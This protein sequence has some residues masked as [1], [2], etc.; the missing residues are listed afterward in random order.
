MKNPTLPLL[1]APKKST[2]SN[3]FIDRYH[4]EIY[5]TS[6]NFELLLQMPNVRA[7]DGMN[8]TAENHTTTLAPSPALM[9]L[10]AAPPPVNIVMRNPA[11]QAA[12]SCRLKDERKRRPFVLCYYEA[13]DFPNQTRSQWAT[14]R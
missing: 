6:N 8:S 4:I 5:V 14:A 10:I 1:F 7:R 11:N 12:G 9:N 13:R 3:P 2:A